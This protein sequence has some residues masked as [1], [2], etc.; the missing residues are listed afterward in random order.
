[1]MIR[2]A[3]LSFCLQQAVSCLQEHEYDLMKYPNLYIYF[4][5]E[6]FFLLIIFLSLQ[7]TTGQMIG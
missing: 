2:E 1:M 3:V 4:F 5:S 7:W 6:S